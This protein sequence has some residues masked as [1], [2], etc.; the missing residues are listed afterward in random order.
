MSIPVSTLTGSN[1]I[2]Q[3]MYNVNTIKDL[4]ANSA[5]FVESPGSSTDN[6]VMRFDG[7]SGRLAQDSS[8]LI[9]DDGSMIISGSSSGDMLRITQTG[10]GNALLVEDSTNPD[11][12]PFVVDA[13][14]NVGIGTSSPGAALDVNK[15]YI[16]LSGAGTDNRSIEIGVGRTGNGLSFIDLIGDTTYS[17]YGVRFIRY[18]T[19]PNT[20]SELQHRGTGPFLINAFDAGSVQLKTS[21]AERM[22][23]DSSGN[24]GI[25]VTDPSEVLEVNGNIKVTENDGSFRTIG[26]DSTSNTT[27]VLQG[28]GPGVAGPN[29]ELARDTNN[30]YD[31]S[32]HIFRTIASSEVMRVDAFNSRVGIGTSSPA[33]QL[34]VLDSNGVGSSANDQQ[35][36]V[37]IEG[38]PGTNE[39]HFEISQLRTSAGSDW[40]TATTRLQQRIDSTYMGW[41]QFNNSGNQGIAFGTGASGTPEGVPERMR[42]VADGKVGI[43]RTPTTNLLEVA[44]TIESTSGGFKFPDGSTQ[45]TS[46]SASGIT[47]GKAIAMA[48]VFG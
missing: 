38:R 19:G 14:G 48:I 32:T 8:V 23:I 5:G 31:A 13:D 15:G 33:A 30:Y 12:T 43:G 37:N 17:D 2:N 7:T 47:T 36:N 27:I 44:G 1:T 16:A 25:G 9:A 21:N 11:S 3:M 4:A 26:A 6:A 41:M 24:V 29:I 22:R 45:T 35:V 28:G 39:S 10:A 46:A 40:T 34:H 18:D 42:I 20:T